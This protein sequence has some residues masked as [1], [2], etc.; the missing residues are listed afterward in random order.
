[1]MFTAIIEQGESGWLVG[2]IKEVPA[3][4]SQGKSIEDLKVNLLD[5]LALALDVDKEIVMNVDY[6]SLHL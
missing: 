4:L 6:S 1:M 2:Q 3:A 5:A